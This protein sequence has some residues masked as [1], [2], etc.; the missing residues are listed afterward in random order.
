MSLYVL[1]IPILPNVASPIEVLID[2]A[3]NNMVTI[4]SVLL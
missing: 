1:Y 4:V 2:L 3:N